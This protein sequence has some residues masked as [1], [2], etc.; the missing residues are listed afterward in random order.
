[1]K[2][3][4]LIIN[5]ITVKTPAPRGLFKTFKLYYEMR[6]TEVLTNLLIYGYL[7][8]GVVDGLITAML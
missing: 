2:E 1:M 6:G 5:N 7:T 4:L 8:G 3:D